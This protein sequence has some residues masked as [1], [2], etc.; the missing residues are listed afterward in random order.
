MVFDAV[1][2]L[3]HALAEIAVV[4]VLRGTLLHV[5]LENGLAAKLD[6][7]YAAPI[8]MWV[9]S[10]VADVHRGGVRRNRTSRHIV[11]TRMR[12]RLNGWW[13]G[14]ALPD[15]LPGIILNLVEERGVR[16][17]EAWCCVGRSVVVARCKESKAIAV[18][19]CHGVGVRWSACLKVGKEKSKENGVPWA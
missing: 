13:E 2:V 16:R 11:V 10:F 15:H 8:L 3:E 12:R 6:E 17:I 18:V 7:T 14:A 4:L 19:V 1:L 9:V 5:H